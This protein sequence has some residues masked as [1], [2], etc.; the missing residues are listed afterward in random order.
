[1]GRRWQAA[2]PGRPSTLARDDSYLRTHV[3]PAFA[4]RDLSEITT[5]DIQQWVH[6]LK[7]RLAPA[8][9]HK[10]LGV[11]SKVLTA[12]LHAGLIDT[13]PARSVTLPRIDPI[14]ARFLA[15]P[16]IDRLE[17][18]VTELSPHWAELVGFLA[19]TGVR[20]GE[21]AALTVADVNLAE[22]TVRVH[23]NL[24]EV[25]GHLHIGAP[26]TR[27]GVRTIPMLTDRT[28]HQLANRIDRLALSACDP[29]LGAPG[30][31]PMR[32]SLMRARV[33]RPAVE[34][35]ELQGRITPTHHA[36]HCDRAVDCCRSG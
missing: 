29:L 19:D 18:A 11:L 23:R 6:D 10:V 22:R 13:N 32:P 14:E 33:W 1:M 7:G 30:G 20:I 35:A 31:G 5:W 24:V 15:P 26:K 34:R 4:E 21:A 36:P 12:A 27:H 2:A 3:L 9:V 8:S 16:E 28:A 25:R 17:A